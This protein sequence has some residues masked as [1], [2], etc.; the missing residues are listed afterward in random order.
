VSLQAATEY[1]NGD[2][3]AA[4]VWRNKYA[5]RDKEGNV[6]ETTPA[7]THR[8]LA[9]EFARIEAKYPNP[10]SEE[11]IFGYLSSW[12]IVPQGSPMSA[13]G[14]QHQIQ[15]L[16]NCLV[17]PSPVDS[18]GGILFSD[19]QLVQL[20]KRRCGVGIDVSPIRPRSMKTS[21]AAGTTDGI[22]VFMERYSNS[23][24]EVAQGGRRGAL[25]ISC[26]CLHPDILTFISIKQ[27]KTK[28][29]GAN[30]SIRMTHEF[31]HAV[32]S[33]S[34][35]VLR[36]PVEATP[37]KALFTKTVKAKEIWDKFVECNWT[38]AEPGLI[39]WD[40]ILENSIP[41]LFGPQFSSVTTNPCS[42]IYLSA[43]DSCR[44]LLVN[45]TKCV[46]SP[47]TKEP[48]FDY[49]GFS[50]ITKISQRLMDDLVDLEIEAIGKILAKIDSDP[51]HESIKQVEKDLWENILSSAKNGRR[52][53]LGITGLGD[54]LAMLG[55]KYGTD[56]SIK[57]T[58]EI[59]K[60]L[61]L[62]SHASSVQLAKERGAFP[63]FNKD[64]VQHAFNNEHPMISRLINYSFDDVVENFAKYGRRN[65]ALTTTA[66]AGSMSIMT[67]TTSGCEPVFM[68]SYKRR[69]KINPN[70]TAATVDFID[71]SG[72]KW[73]EH[74]VHH[75]GLKLWMEVTGETDITK[76]P[77][78][79]ATSPDI[80]WDKSVELQA[81]AQKWIEH[82]ISKTCNLPEHV[83]KEQVSD[84]YFKAW[85]SGCKGFTIYREGS[86]SGVLVANEPKKE[87]TIVSTKAPKRPAVLKCDIHR[88][89]ISGESYV[90]LVGLL[91]NQPYEVFCGLS[92]NIGL[93]KSKITG[94][95]TKRVVKTGVAAYDLAIPSGDDEIVIADVVNLFD[96][97]LYG[98]FTRTLSLSL[99]HGVPVQFIVEQLRKDKHSDMTSFASAVA[100]VLSKHYIAD[101]TK[102]TSEKKCS[103]CQSENISYLS[104][105]ATCMNCGASKCS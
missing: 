14:N 71:Q 69:K 18:Y 72:D 82:S 10:L 65:I 95:I 28:V 77:Y 47:F 24:R 42:E 92:K 54:A 53:G 7:D 2:E 68:L 58:E 74:V 41:D 67:Q 15:S 97:P 101:G 37:E 4:S 94:T 80:D 19:Q 13:I 50:S 55:V 25:M 36:W 48:R 20:M 63:A 17:V 86:R 75:H 59:Y 39:F 8:R 1:F 11:E 64:T 76:S 38:S 100:R 45:V 57:V 22:G 85:K 78:W 90:M 40:N 60:T 5:L 44:L 98:A 73:S 103:E 46:I 35:V 104:G 27:D 43:Y 31:M 12:T 56:E 91:N 51:E 83:T 6:V 34:D 9:K 79:G 89:T 33:D 3:L 99:R 66:P 32:E 105:C 30:V 87:E 93:P 88:T 16:S 49:Q 70:D 84:L 26:H 23:C 21:N 29:T 61:E 62:N 81:A 96:N 52:T 102:V